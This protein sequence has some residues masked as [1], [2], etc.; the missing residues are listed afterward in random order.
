MSSLFHF[1][2][3]LLQV[4]Q[5]SSQELN[6]VL[7]STES[8]VTLEWNVEANATSYQVTWHR[9]VGFFFIDEYYEAPFPEDGKLVY[10]TSYL[11]PGVPYTFLLFRNGN[12]STDR[13]FSGD[14]FTGRF[15]LRDCICYF[16]VICVNKLYLLF[17]CYLPLNKQH[18]GIRPVFRHL[19]H[20]FGLYADKRPTLPSA[21]Y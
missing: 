11:L 14:I 8:T 15:Q 19:A 1:Q 21:L 17:Y 4:Q 2:V 3:C 6:P 7:T 18:W 12:L 5:C 10:R 20:S 16:I 9:T 13:I